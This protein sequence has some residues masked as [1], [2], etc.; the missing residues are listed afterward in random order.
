[1][2]TIYLVNVG[3]N[4]SHATTARSPV[5]PDGRFT[6]VSFPTR[7]RDHTQIY[8]N[9]A[10]QYVR[11]AD[12]WRTHADPDW[13]NLTYGDYCA[14]PRAGALKKAQKGDIL[15]FWGLLWHNHGNDWRSFSGSREWFLLGAIRIEEIL[16]GGESPDT[17]SKSSRV[18]ARHNAHLS[19][20]DRLPNGHYV[21]VGNAE[22]SRVFD[23]AVPLET[24]RSEGLI[25]RAFTAANGATL[26][27]DGKP[28]WKSSLRSCRPIW[29]LGDP[30]ARSR[31]D[32]VASEIRRQ[33]DFDLLRDIE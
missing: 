2:A 31:A 5:F 11:G 8:S 19:G 10:R 18:R 15:L 14:N 20:R 30:V 3:A 24:S 21:F 6:F 1:M 9:A 33:N 7:S 17:L 25:Y 27:K 23:H 13:A 28:A 22:Y 16:R 26:T 4:S 12:D 32:V 29:N